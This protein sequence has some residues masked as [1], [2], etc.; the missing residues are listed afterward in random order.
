MC[1]S[2]CRAGI[3]GYTH[4]F[5]PAQSLGA[6][7]GAPPE[8][9]RCAELSKDCA[10]LCYL[11][12]KCE[13]VEIIAWR[14]Q[15]KSRNFCWKTGLL[16]PALGR[17]TGREIAGVGGGDFS[18]AHHPQKQPDDFLSLSAFLPLSMSGLCSWN[19]RLGMSLN[20]GPGLATISQKP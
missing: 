14:A 11:A 19:L 12:V 8:H 3:R 4:A 6:R 17:S 5:L 1:S 2:V 16:D 15:V 7:R 20:S 10:L 13:A 18:T 9:Q